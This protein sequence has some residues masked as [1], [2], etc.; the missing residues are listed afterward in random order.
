MPIY[1]TCNLLMDDDE[2]SDR[3]WSQR[4]EPEGRIF[5]FVFFRIWYRRFLA[6]R[7]IPNVDNRNNSEPIRH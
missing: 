7:R 6:S 4:A 2:Q 1:G 5:F 3:G